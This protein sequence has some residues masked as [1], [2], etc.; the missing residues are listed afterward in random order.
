MRQSVLDAMPSFHL[1]SLE[2]LFIVDRQAGIEK[3]GYIWFEEVEAFP[4]ASS[5]RLGQ[6]LQSPQIE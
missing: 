1:C 3:K 4:D 2:H 6:D 5:I